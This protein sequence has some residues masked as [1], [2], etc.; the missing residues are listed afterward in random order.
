[1]PN[2]ANP[3]APDASASRTRLEWIDYLR[4]LVI[5]LV[6]IQHACVTYSHVGSWYVLSPHE[7]SWTVKL[8][9]IV[10]ETVM[11]SFFM[12]VLFFIAGYFAY[13]SIR[14]RGPGSFARERLFRLGLPALLYMLVIHP[15]ILI[16][17]N[18]WHNDFG[19]WAAFYEKF[20]RSGSVL[21]ASGPMWF[22]VA[23]LIFCLIFALGRWASNGRIPALP[24]KK[25]SGWIMAGF[26]VLLGIA[27]FLIRLWQPLGSSV[28]NMQLGYFA[29]YVGFFLVGL[30]AGRGGWIVI[31]AQSR[32]S[33]RVGLAALI[34]APLALIA[35]IRVGE[36]ERTT[37]PFIG[38]WHWEAAALAL[39]EQ[40]AGMGLSLGLLAFTCQ[41]LNGEI[42]ILRW[43]SDRSFSVYLLHPPILIGLYMLAAKFSWNPMVLAAL[44]SLAAL[45][46]SFAVAD[47]ARRIPGLRRIV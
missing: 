32:S 35:L 44:L 40:F 2:P 8:F 14:R 30:A 18:P 19:P 13:G 20:I 27:N 41:I 33:S 9:F 31:L 43:L 36:A 12:G 6:V 4:T 42:A 25:P 29:Q 28:L 22:A 3:V 15:F 24:D 45:A 10:W 39:W 47:I 16:G 17:L 34:L 38:G 26:A 1:M 46:C 23:L 37:L 11:Q 7:P 21:S 5:F